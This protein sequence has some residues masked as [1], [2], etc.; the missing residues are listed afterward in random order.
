MVVGGGGRGRV[1]GP[2]SILFRSMILP[3][4]YATLKIPT[5]GSGQER[6]EVKD[7]EDWQEGEEKEDG[8]E[9]ERRGRTE[10]Q[11]EDEMR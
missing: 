10:G 9:R 6:R 3:Y 1:H 8:E 2:W 11:G 4:H 7:R 5:S